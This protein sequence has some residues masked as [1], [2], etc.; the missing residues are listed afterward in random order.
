MIVRGGPSSHVELT[1]GVFY[2]KQEVTWRSLSTGISSHQS[3]IYV[4]ISQSFKA[5]SL[6]VL[7]CQVT[8]RFHLES[9]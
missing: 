1:L 9:Y 2:T 3:L 5:D 7:F 6:E 8:E 4:P